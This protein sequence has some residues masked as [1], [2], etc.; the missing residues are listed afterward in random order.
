M[1]ELG[2]R[3][4]PDACPA[5]KKQ[6]QNRRAQQNSQQLPDV[7]GAP[8]SW[9]RYQTRGMSDIGTEP[10]VIFDLKALGVD[11]RAMERSAEA[12]LDMWMRTY[13][14]GRGRIPENVGLIP[15]LGPTHDIPLATAPAAVTIER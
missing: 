1:T 15:E 8:P 7:A 14:P 11:T 10:A 4:G 2:P 12:Y 5:A 3:F 9:S 6:N 13:D